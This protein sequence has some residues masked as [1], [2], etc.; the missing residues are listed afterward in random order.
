MFNKSKQTYGPYSAITTP[1]PI[2]SILQFIL[3][4]L[5]NVPEAAMQLK[6]VDG[7]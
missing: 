6:N 4:V 1:V 3:R 2:D 5:A 7:K